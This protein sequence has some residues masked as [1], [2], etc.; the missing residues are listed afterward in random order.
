M[1]VAEFASIS[2]NIAKHTWNCLNKLVWLCQGSK[3][4]WSSYMFDRILDIS[5]VLNTPWLWIWHSSI[6][7]CY[8]ELSI[9]LNMAQY[10]IHLPKNTSCCLSVPQYA[11][12]CWNI[13]ECPWQCLN[14]LFWLCQGLD[15]RD[16]L[17]YLTESVIW[18]KYYI[19]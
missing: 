11:W 2:Q 12:T 10:P 9:C 19:C 1:I 3:Y 13:A 6:C 14:K 17:R 4:A 18:L 7:K 16:Q 5:H 15:M 8:K